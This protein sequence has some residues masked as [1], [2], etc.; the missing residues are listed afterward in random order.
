M[1]PHE[2]G[3]SMRARTST[4]AIASIVTIGV[5]VGSVVA[6]P[7][8]LSV[9]YNGAIVFNHVPPLT[10][11]DG[12]PVRLELR[13]RSFGPQQLPWARTKFADFQCIYRRSGERVWRQR[14]MAAFTQEHGYDSVVGIDLPPM[15]A[16]GHDNL[17]YY[18]SYTKDGHTDTV[19]SVNGGPV[20][21]PFTPSK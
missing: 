11:G 16:A 9:F 1:L 5:I 13:I 7:R 19:G 6:L 3:R 20:I 14:P 18:F 4:I 2:Q 10:V 8:V 21:V 15:S 17:E 12:S